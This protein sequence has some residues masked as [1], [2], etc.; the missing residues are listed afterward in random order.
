M[1]Q[2]VRRFMLHRVS[3]RSM[4]WRL[5]KASY[6]PVAW[7]IGTAY[8][9]GSHRLS[10]PPVI[11]GGAPRSGTTILLSVLSAHPHIQAIPHET[12]AFCPPQNAS[13]ARSPEDFELHRVY[14]PLAL[15]PV[16]STATRWAEKTP[17]NILSFGAILDYFGEDVRL[18][19]IVRPRKTLGYRTPADILA[20]TVASTG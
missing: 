11:I 4:A 8:R 17:R 16:K 20:E 2:A 7:A 3:Q 1:Y 6:R 10:G 5:L 9:G 13:G 12:F 19:H 14:A 15:S 18:I